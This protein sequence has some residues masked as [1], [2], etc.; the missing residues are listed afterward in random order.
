VDTQASAQ[1]EQQ[2]AEAVLQELVSQVTDRT[3]SPV[4]IETVVTFGRPWLELLKQARA[5]KDTL[6]VCGTRDRGAL[7][8]MLFG[9]TGQKLLRNA[10]GP[11]WLVK[12]RIDDDALMDILV[13]S[14]LSEIGSE[15]IHTG[16]AIAQA[17]PSRMSLLHVVDDRLDRHMARTGV[18]EDEIAEYREKL[19]NDAEHALHEQLSMTDYR[20]LEHG[21]Q[22]HVAEG[23]ADAAILEAIGEL[24]AD[25][26]IMATSG[27][28]GVPGMLFGNTAERLLPDLPCSVLAIKPDDFQ[29]PV[30]I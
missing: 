22:C 10:P 20:T 18:S 1:S 27:R 29:C 2:E 23:V 25:L 13:T 8:R 4:Q 16:V 14:D 24:D 12:P 9:S 28:G 17:I 7:K 19:R 15:L 26:L 3:T 6:I 11:V 5:A 21:V 30:Q